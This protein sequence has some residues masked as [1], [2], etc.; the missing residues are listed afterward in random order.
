MTRI[1][2][3]EQLLFRPAVPADAPRIQT[4]IRQAQAQMQ[5]AGSL[6]WQNGYPGPEHIAADLLRGYGRVLCRPAASGD[7]EAVAY[8]AVSFDGEPAYGAIE[9][10]RSSDDAYVVLHR[11]AVAD[12]AKRQGVAT[13]FFHR[14][15]ELARAR[16]VWFFRVDTNFD[17]HYMLHLLEREG[18]AY[19]GKICYDSGER[20]AFEKALR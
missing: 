10:G 2:C 1:L 19:R 16:G 8:G 15:E 17:N 20:L 3:D 4:I 13:A 7:A 9:G 6:Q 14:T 5:A 12:E 18:F 11:L